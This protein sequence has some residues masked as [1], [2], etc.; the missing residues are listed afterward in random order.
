MGLR[1][2]A[3]KVEDQ[4]VGTVPDARTVKLETFGL[5]DK[6]SYV[7]LERGTAA[8]SQHGTADGAPTRDDDVHPPMDVWVF[9]VLFLFVALWVRACLVRMETR[10][11]ILFKPRVLPDAQRLVQTVEPTGT[12]MVMAGRAE[13]Q[14]RL[15]S[16]TGRGVQTEGVGDPTFGLEARHH[17]DHQVFGLFLVAVAEHDVDV[18]AL[19]LPPAVPADDHALDV[20]GPAVLRGPNPQDAPGVAQ[21]DTRDA[22]DLGPGDLGQELVVV[23]DPD[24]L[25]A[26]EARPAELDHVVQVPPAALKVEFPR[27]VGTHAPYVP[28]QPEV[29]EVVVVVERADRR[30][31]PLPVRVGRVVPFGP[32]GRELG[33]APGEAGD[34]VR[35]A[36]VVFVGGQAGD[37]RRVGSH[38]DVVEREEPRFF[39]L[40]EL[41]DEGGVARDHRR[42]AATR[43]V[44]VPSRGPVGQGWERVV[45]EILELGRRG[46]MEF[47]WVLCLVG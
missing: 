14:G 11:R 22:L 25:D 40:G 36:D 8:P 44:R 10:K 1:P 47:R 30:D 37:G 31:R 34:L 3:L 15:P 19:G 42:V 2:R 21:D 7:P 43:V 39:D 26:R 28:E 45:G 41:C 13:R 16:I 9:L 18:P 33:V 35:V 20:L 17:V 4:A 38:A 6:L 23:L 27:R 32:Q 24:L 5:V 12:V 29:P 46:A